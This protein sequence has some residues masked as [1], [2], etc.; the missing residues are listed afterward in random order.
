MSSIRDSTDTPP[1]PLTD[2]G[3]PVPAGSW[4]RKLIHVAVSLVAAAVVWRL[5]HPAGAAVLAAA[6]S[7]A[8]SIELARRASPAFGL[9]FQR[10]VGP[11]L[12]SQ[13]S[14]RLTGATT[15]A[16]GFTLAA[17]LFPG[18]P[19]IAGIL[20]AGVADPAAALIGRRFGRRRYR[21]GKSM[22]G[23]VAFLAVTFLLLLAV[24]GLGP[25][26]AAIVAAVLAMAEAPSLRVDDNLYLPALAALLL[27]LLGGFLAVGGF[28]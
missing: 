12:T 9:A 10:L 25:A 8:L 26:G 17:T 23:S 3:V 22:E 16:M 18:W 5:P 28:S 24:P 6:T 14:R 7:I 11:M 4:A 13:E 19:A 21:G 15:L 27:F 2:P 20:I 1:R